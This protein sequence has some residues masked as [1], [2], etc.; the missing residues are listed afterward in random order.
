MIGTTSIITPSCP[1]RIRKGRKPACTKAFE[2]PAGPIVS[3]IC[4]Q[5]FT[6]ILA[7]RSCVLTRSASVARN[8]EGFMVRLGSISILVIALFAAL[9]FH[10]QAQT[11]P[12]A[13][14]QKTD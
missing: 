10:P 2:A 9:E 3:E 8:R 12:P 7:I 5:L 6:V 13:A 11:P 1:K 14:A 4:Q